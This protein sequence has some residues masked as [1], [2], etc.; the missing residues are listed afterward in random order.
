MRLRIPTRSGLIAMGAAA[1]L[2]GILLLAA[3]LYPRFRR[4]DFV[5]AAAM[6]N[7]PLAI[8]SLL[9]PRTDGG[10]STCRLRWMA[11]HTN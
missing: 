9:Q 10:E 11:D 3:L 5:N 8:P 1:L 6:L 2:V 4:V 7:R